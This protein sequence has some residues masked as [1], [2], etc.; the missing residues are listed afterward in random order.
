M[1]R[2]IVIR[3]SS[4]WANGNLED[5]TCIASVL[6]F[7]PSLAFEYKCFRRVLWP[8]NR[9]TDVMFRM[10]SD[11]VHQGLHYPR[12]SPSGHLGHWTKDLTS[13]DP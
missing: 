7:S 6:P 8:I 4:W 2:P 5:S 10:I 11:C 1:R 13:G 3:F 12:S 9:S